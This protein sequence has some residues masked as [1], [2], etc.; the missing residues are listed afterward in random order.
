M[1][2]KP[3]KPPPP[4]TKLIKCFFSTVNSDKAT[5]YGISNNQIRA[6][7]IINSAGWFNSA[8]ERL[9]KGDLSLKDMSTISKNIYPDDL[10]IALN[11]TDSFHNMPTGLDYLAPGRDY[12]LN[13]AVWVIG[14]GGVIIRVREDI[15]KNE[16]AENDGVKYVRMGKKDFL[17]VSKGGSKKAVAKDSIPQDEHK[18]SPAVPTTT[19]T[20]TAKPVGIASKTPA[21]IAKTVAAPLK[22]PTKMP[23]TIKK[24][25]T[26]T[27]APKP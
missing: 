2:P 12:V 11:E 14:S 10:F 4:S 7:G 19:N 13:H 25:S 15:S 18:T 22:A 1:L 8:G 3:K 20:A 21:T 16:D 27:V 23:A 9:G 24:V 5:P 26:N 6:K 17:S